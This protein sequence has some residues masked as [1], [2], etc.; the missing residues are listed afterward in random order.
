M[1]LTFDERVII[2]I[3]VVCLALASS[4][5]L[6]QKA[7]SRWRISGVSNL[8]L[9]LTLLYY[10]HYFIEVPSHGIGMLLL[11][12]VSTW[13]VWRHEATGKP[14]ITP[15]MLVIFQLLFTIL[16]V[17]VVRIQEA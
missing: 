14:N 10:Y 8:L 3:V 1:N 5:F 9:S 12:I 17:V 4:H 11:P 15:R 6:M 13:L 2:T 16:Y 7:P